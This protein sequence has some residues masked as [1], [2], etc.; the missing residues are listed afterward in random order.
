MF[1]LEYGMSQE[2]LLSP[3]LFNIL[4]EVQISLIRQEKEMRHPYWRGRKKIIFICRWHCH[5]RKILINIF[6]NILEQVNLVTPLSMR[7]IYKKTCISNTSNKQLKNE[8]KSMIA[9]TMVLKISIVLRN[10][11]NKDW[12][13]KHAY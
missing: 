4:L 3:L 1:Y 8:I 11:F 6:K 5:V 2:C 7:S 12:C 10:K 9:F 13:V